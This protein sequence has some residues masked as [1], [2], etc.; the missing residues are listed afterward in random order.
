MLL[1]MTGRDAGLEGDGPYQDQSSRVQA[2]VSDSGPI[3]LIEQYRSGVLRQVCSRFM[4]GPPEGERAITYRKAS[5]SN[6]IAGQLP[7]FLLL[8][9]VDDAQVPV[10]T[11]DQF[12]LA[13]G[14][15]GVNDVS[16][17][18][19]AHVDHCP[20]SLMRVAALRPI[21]NEFFLRIVDAARAK[22]T[23]LSDKHQGRA[24]AASTRIV[25]RHGR[26]VI[27]FV[28]AVPRPLIAIKPDHR[29]LG[30]SRRP[31]LAAIRQRPLL[32]LT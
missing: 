28:R 31:A 32:T 13:L 7:P 11:A 2:V 16:Y 27:E 18:R 21:V 19:L 1:G 25:D 15:A 4:G 30:E 10:E 5:P 29:P 12:V 9:G 23:E 24:G 20:Y 22:R 6:R 26:P 17:H 3:D 8:Y 14:R